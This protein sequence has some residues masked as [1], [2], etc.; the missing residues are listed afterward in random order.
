[1]TYAALILIPII[2]LV[3]AVM[4]AP[5][6]Q[7][8]LRAVTRG[9]RNAGASAQTLLGQG[10]WSDRLIG[11]DPRGVVRTLGAYLLRKSA[12]TLDRSR[13]P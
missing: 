13:A 8:A 6:R 3:S 2:L 5:A 7:A 10:K 1:M 4:D 9:L 11:P 12:D